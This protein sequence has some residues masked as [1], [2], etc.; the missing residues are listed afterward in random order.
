M[1]VCKAGWRC[2]AAEAAGGWALRRT[3]TKTGCRLEG[4]P[5]AV[6]K[7]L[8]M[9]T[10]SDHIVVFQPGSAYLKIG[11]ASKAQPR[12]VPQVVARRLRCKVDR[13]GSERQTDEREREATRRQ[14]EEQLRIAGNV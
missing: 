4:A 2:A 14:H 12:L 7:L 1:D 10:P 5:P 3:R 11:L 13:T 6:H 8:A 9:R